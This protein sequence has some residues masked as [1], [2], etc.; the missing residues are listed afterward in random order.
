MSR[1]KIELKNLQNLQSCYDY[2]SCQ[3]KDQDILDTH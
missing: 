1:S 2:E 3:G